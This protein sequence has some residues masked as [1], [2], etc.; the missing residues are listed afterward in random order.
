MSI[1]VNDPALLLDFIELGFG[2][3]LLVTEDD[4]EDAAGAGGE[5]VAI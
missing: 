2:S 5:V 4:D 3:G 1:W